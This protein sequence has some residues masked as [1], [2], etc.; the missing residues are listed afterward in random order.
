MIQCELAWRAVSPGRT[1]RL[2]QNEYG[3]AVLPKFK[4]VTAVAADSAASKHS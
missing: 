3:H 4:A 1:V 2:N